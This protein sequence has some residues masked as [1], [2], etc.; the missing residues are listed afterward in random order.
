MNTKNHQNRPQCK[1]CSR[2]LQRYG[3]TAAGTIRY[4]CAGCGASTVS[5][6]K[7][8]PSRR[9]YF[10]LFREYILDGVTYQYLFK[11]NGVT[12]RTL[13]KWFHQYFESEPPRLP[14]PPLDQEY[15]YLIIDGKWNGKKEVAMLY[16]RSDTKTIL[17]VSFMKKE[18]AS[19]IKKDLQ[20]LIDSGFRCSGVVS[21]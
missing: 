10:S 6:Q 20:H 8:F 14:L 19:L 18:Y 15:L 11:K 9:P 7:K 13:L 17:H 3:K 4:R 1:A 16:R 2:K 21:D 12:K 5:H